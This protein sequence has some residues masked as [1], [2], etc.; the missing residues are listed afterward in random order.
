MFPL[1]DPSAGSQGG[2][3]RLEYLDSLVS[4]V[5]VR[6]TECHYLLRLNVMRGIGTGLGNR[7]S[8]Y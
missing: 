4:E 3:F 1:Y 2:T 5:C 8:N 7:F 6:C